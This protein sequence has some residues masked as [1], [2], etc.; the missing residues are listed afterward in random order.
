MRHYYFSLEDSGTRIEYLGRVDLAND[1]EALSFGRRLVRDLREND[2][3]E[4]RWSLGVT[5]GGRAVASIPLEFAA[6]RG[7]S[8]GNGARRTAPGRGGARGPLAAAPRNRTI[9]LG[10]SV[11]TCPCH[12]CAIFSSKEEENAVLLPFMAEGIAAGDRCVNI[13]NGTH[14]EE[15]LQS[16]AA[17]G[18]DVANAEKTGQLELR[19]WEQ[20]HLVEGRFD[21]NA[22]LDALDNAAA[23]GGSDF[24]RTR[25][26]SNQEWALLD[27]P[28]VEDIVEY[29]CRFNYIWPKYN[30]A[31][32][33]VYDS[34][35]FG[36]D[37]LVQI[38]RTHPLVIIGGVLREN[39][40]YVPPD[41]LLIEL[42]TRG[43]S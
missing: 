32:V 39:M 1:E 38:L 19:A 10:G 8:Q 29:E 30:D 16:L 3:V 31:I 42:Q 37:L 41:D 4:A 14:R 26:W 13:I 6:G 43:P 23:N 18:I 24:P 28:G 5:E 12:V 9:R 17:A 22:M 33:C 2:A 35:K 25:L 7:G 27:V 40:F 21:Q 36:A 11:H 15:R 34:S 20:A